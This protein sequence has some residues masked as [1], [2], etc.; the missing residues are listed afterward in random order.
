MKE[1]GL[2]PTPYTY[3]IIFRGLARNVERS[4][5]RFDIVDQ[6]LKVYRQ[7]EIRSK[8]DV[9]SIH[10]N[11]LLN[12]C[13]KAGNMEA[14]WKVAG[15][16]E[17]QGKHAPNA[18][19]YTTIIRALTRNGAEQVEEKEEDGLVKRFARDP[20]IRSEAV[21]DAEGLWQDIMHRWRTGD[22]ELDETLV[23]AMAG[24]YLKSV[25]RDDCTKVFSLLEDTMGIVNTERR[26]N[27]QSTTSDEV[28]STDR[29]TQ[30]NK[31]IPSQRTLTT[32][33][34]A[35]NQ[36]RLKKVLLDYWELLTSP[37]HPYKI[38]PDCGNY[39]DHMRGLRVSRSSADMAALLT[40]L[41]DDPRTTSMAQLWRRVTF[42]LAIA[43]CKRDV[44]NRN[45]FHN[46]NM[47]MDVMLQKIP[48]PCSD[49]PENYPT[50]ELLLTYLELAIGTQSGSQDQASP[51]RVT[52]AGVPIRAKNLLKAIPRLFPYLE[53]LP[54]FEIEGKNLL[55]RD[56]IGACDRLI[57]N[58]DASLIDKT[59]LEEL[60][61]MKQISARMQFEAKEKILEKGGKPAPE[62]DEVVSGDQPKYENTGEG[63]FS[64]FW[65]RKSRSK[66]SEDDFD[67]FADQDE[68]PAA[69][70]ADNSNMDSKISASET[71]SPTRTTTTHGDTLSSSK[72]PSTS[73]FSDFEMNAPFNSLSRTPASDKGKK[74][75]EKHSS[76]AF[77]RDPYDDFSR[78]LGFDKDKKKTRSNSS[79]RSGGDRE[80]HFSSPRSSSSTKAWKKGA[81]KTRS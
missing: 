73:E 42:S 55:L 65:T 28:S 33:I 40:K 47:I 4:T 15:H 27:G 45:A 35:C 80:H 25:D 79:S 54:E 81:R 74:S 43:S 70:V 44:F 12:V 26:E 62:F 72:S 37:E 10:T 16:F 20:R 59:D 53:S 77:G 3:T 61:S 24:V 7:L 14:L 71:T 52:Q 36:L 51:S 38:Q 31:V 76:S 48:P 9:S 8:K 78:S 5:A 41:Y 66:Y 57:N 30:G 2:E 23:N 11:A 34:L 29:P 64:S 32:L 56:F 58:K 49:H 75:F 68:T 60:K 18:T 39:L 19:T 46:A 6:A 50:P 63:A 22:L 13:A 1:R 17:E 69:D 21:K 67:I